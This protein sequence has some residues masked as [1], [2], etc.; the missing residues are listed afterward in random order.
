VAEVAAFLADRARRRGT[1]VDRRV[2]D[3]AALLHDLDKALPRSHPLLSLGHGHAGAAWLVE[4]GQA[5]LAPP[6]G[7]HPVGRLS[8]SSYER[9]I[10][11]STWEERIVAYADKRAIQRVGSIDRRFDHWLREH[12]ELEPELRI[13]RARAELLE[14]EV[15]GVAGVHPDQVRRL[16]WVQP[17]LEQAADRAAA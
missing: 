5:E 2:V 16:R 11:G 15:C 8:E 13:A 1:R 14:R 7:C 4:H 10:A 12:P 3:A 17:A 9:W 6:V